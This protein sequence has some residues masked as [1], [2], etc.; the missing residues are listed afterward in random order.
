MEIISFQALGAQVRGYL[1]DDYDTLAAHKV[2]PALVIC[3]GGAYRWRSPREKDPPAF[4]F[5]SMGWQVFILEYSCTG[6]AGEYRPLR[7]LA[8]TVRQL[9]ARQEG[10]HIDRSKIAVLGFSAGGHLA[11]SLGALWNDPVLGLPP[12]S[13]PDALA[14][15]YPVIATKG[16]FAHGESADWVSGGD[17]AVRD[18]LHL[19]D[20]VTADFPPP[21][22]WHGGEDASV[23]PENSLLLAVELR[24]HGVPFE[25]H[26]FGSGAH[27]ISTCTQEVE[28]P[29][30]VCRA[31][32]PL[33][34]GWLNRRFE[35]TP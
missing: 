11:A 24:K 32:V 21:F 19:W 9:R 13:R 15:C 17:E 25:Y 14:L 8:E 4:E 34:K 10:W 5:L 22:L 7:E 6:E 28:T 27:G 31:W 1:Q 20:R 3:P 29:D 30:G 26:L 16:G 2:R 33:C 12:E 18:K 35:Y 23:P